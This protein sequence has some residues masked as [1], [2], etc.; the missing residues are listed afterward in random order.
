MDENKREKDYFFGFTIHYKPINKIL[1]KA[2]LFNL[3][4][5]MDK[6]L[7][8]NAEYQF[9]IAYQIFNIKFKN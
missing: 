2:S 7:S 6:M 8:E 4:Q 5:Q 9:G 3:M 1:I